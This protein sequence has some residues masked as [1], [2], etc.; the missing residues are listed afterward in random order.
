M[1]SIQTSNV[2]LQ[3]KQKH[4]LKPLK[5]SKYLKFVFIPV[6]DFFDPGYLTL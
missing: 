5:I 2:S 1:T 3:L 6:N 4:N